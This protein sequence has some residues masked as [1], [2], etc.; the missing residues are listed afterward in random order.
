MPELQSNGAKRHQL[1]EEFLLLLRV[2]P[3][4]I[5]CV[6]NVAFHTLFCIVLAKGAHRSLQSRP[7]CLFVHCLHRADIRVRDNQLAAVRIGHLHVARRI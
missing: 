7:K 3:I 6:R 5:K 2:K 1:L 4:G